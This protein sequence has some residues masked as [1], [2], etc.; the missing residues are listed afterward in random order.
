MLQFP[1]GDQKW[2]GS[3]PLFRRYLSALSRGSRTQPP[4]VKE[5]VHEYLPGMGVAEI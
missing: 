5:G 4:G 2:T 1:A 3:Y